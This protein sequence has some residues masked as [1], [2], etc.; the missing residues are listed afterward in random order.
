MSK[1]NAASSAV[2]SLTLSRAVSNTTARIVRDACGAARPISAR[3]LL[4]GGQT[5]LGQHVGA[6]RVFARRRE[7]NQVPSDI[8]RLNPR[9]HLSHVVRFVEAVASGVRGDRGRPQVRR[10]RQPGQDRNKPYAE[11]RA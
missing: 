5:R 2:Y 1:T 11:L 6:W 3:S 10:R 9:P 4:Q 8:L 7:V